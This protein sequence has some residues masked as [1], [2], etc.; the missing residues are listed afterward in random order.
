MVLQLLLLTVKLIL[1]TKHLVMISGMLLLALI[2][3]VQPQVEVG[4]VIIEVAIKVGL[5]EPEKACDKDF[6]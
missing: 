5:I 2:D 3:S 1:L 4:K 6:V